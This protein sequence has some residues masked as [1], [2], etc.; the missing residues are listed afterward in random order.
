[1]SKTRAS[2]GD[3]ELLSVDGVGAKTADNLLEQFGSDAVVLDAVQAVPSWVRE[4]IAGVGETNLSNLRAY[5]A[6]QGHPDQTDRRLAGLRGTKFKG[7]GNRYFYAVGQRSDNVCLFYTGYH[8]GRSY[9]TTAFGRQ[10]FTSDR[11]NVHA[12]TFFSFSE[13]EHVVL[14]YERR[15]AT[16]YI[17]DIIEA[18]EW[19]NITDTGAVFYQRGRTTG[20]DDYPMTTDGWSQSMGS[21]GAVSELISLELI[22]IT[23]DRIALYRKPETT[24]IF[25]FVI[26]PNQDRTLRRLFGHSKFKTD[27]EYTIGEF[28][29]IETFIKRLTEDEVWRTKFDGP[30][31]T[32]KYEQYL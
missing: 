1:M 29:T 18:H 30:Y 10:T 7:R 15:T 19:K 14:E 17:A 24:A 16:N 23:K 9:K 6:E 21:T 12:W 26:E 4:N 22:G 32:E 13:Y 25:A 2:N 5:A 8:Q 3:T 11:V 28:G 20:L 27:R 31:V